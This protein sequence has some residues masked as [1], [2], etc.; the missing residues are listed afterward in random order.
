MNTKLNST[1]SAI[2]IVINRNFKLDIVTLKFELHVI[3]FDCF[4]LLFVCGGEGRGVHEVLV[5]S[6]SAIFMIKTCLHAI[7]VQG[8]IYFDRPLMV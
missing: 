5:S 6:I 7:N 4:Y 2:F 3:C 1:V 8:R